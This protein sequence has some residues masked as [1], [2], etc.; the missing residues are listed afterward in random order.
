MYTSGLYRL[1]SLY[2]AYIVIQLAGDWFEKNAFFHTGDFDKVLEAFEF[3]SGSND[4][5]KGGAIRKFEDRLINAC[6]VAAI[7]RSNLVEFII[8]GEKMK[9]SKLSS[10]AIT[11]AS[12]CKSKSLKD[13][14]RYKEIS[15][16][17]RSKIN[18]KRVTFLEDNGDKCDVNLRMS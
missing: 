11:L 15:K 8:A 3:L 5:D 1:K 4:K 13:Q 17:T 16:N 7:S 18:E 9:L 14:K 2:E 12:K 10:S 6:E